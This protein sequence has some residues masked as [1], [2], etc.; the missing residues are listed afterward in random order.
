MMKLLF[1]ILL[2][3][4]SCQNAT[5]PST[6]FVRINISSDPQTLDPRKMRNLTSITLARMFFEGLTRIS[7][8]GEIELGIASSVQVNE[9]GDQ[10]TFTLRKTNW[11]DG[12]PVT[13][14]DFAE[15][16]KT[17]LSPSF[18]TDIAYQLYIIKNGKKAKLSEV[19]LSEIG[20]QTPDAQTLVITLETPIPYF[21]EA[22]SMPCFFAVPTHIANAN[23]NWV[24]QPDTFVG[25]GPFVLQEWKHSDVM[26]VEKNKK[27][28]E[29]NKIR[30]PGI[31][32]VMVSSDTEI[33]MFQEGELDWAGSPLSTIPIDAV[34]HLKQQ[35][36]LHVSP[37]LATYFFRVNTECAP[38]NN[39]NLR[40]AMALC[41]DRS[42]IVEHVLQG[43]QKEATGLVPPEM[44]INEQGYFKV[45]LTLAKQLF[46]K[47]L[48]EIGE[49]LGPISL[50]TVAT[51]ERDAA[52]AAVV[53]KQ[54]EKELGLKITLEVIEPKVFFQR[55]SKKEYQ[56]ATGSWTADFNDPMNFLEVFKYKSGSTNNT[57]WEN[58]RYVDLLD[59]IALCKDLKEKKAQMR[60]AEQILM[61]EMP[62]IP[63]YH[64]VLNYLKKS[65]LEEVA[66]SP[67]GQVD[68]R[69]AHF[70]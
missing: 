18:P 48:K 57:A 34:A 58:R 70:Q 51:S 59:R 21:L 63:L 42:A 8:T 3:L 50:S 45:D 49:P 53:Q 27:Y 24:L 67:L 4:T 46:A 41:L 33:R 23:P 52:I 12:T 17:I 31:E 32:M 38:L 56:I 20:I 19:S 14:F 7:K 26:K 1:F 10:Y 68:F 13:S 44:G 35:Q 16:W 30:I 55:I 2:A 25:N 5:K 37:F 54:W 62:I 15:S 47:A 61:D 69:W 11:S 28:W 40:Q 36:Q 60:E 9:T 6:P 66:L 65:E 29:E 64:F 22:L 39:K 43:G